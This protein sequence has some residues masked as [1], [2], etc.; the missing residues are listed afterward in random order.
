MRILFFISLMTSFVL[1]GC[2]GDDYI[3]DFVNPGVRI[4]NPADT[5]ALGS[6][7]Q[8]EA[9][10]FDGVG[11]PQEKV[12][13]WTSSDELVIAIT[14]DG[15]AEALTDGE[16][17]ITVTVS[18]DPT[19]SNSKLVA[20]GLNTVLPPQER[21]ATVASTSSYALEGDCSLH[22]EGTQLVLEF[23]SN[24]HTSDELPGLF[25]YLTNNPETTSGA[26]QIG[27]VTTFNGAHSYD[28]PNSI[29]LYDYSHVLFFCAPFN[30]KVGDGQLSN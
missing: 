20:T 21:F 6:S 2:I 28:L 16:S 24:F 12:L 27:P 15:L 7:Y 23:E 22:Y 1:V 3:D 18:D 19:I 13:V 9:T 4:T 14:D 8:F 11:M 26:Y 25:L 29:G 10:Y 5:L 30:V 17:L